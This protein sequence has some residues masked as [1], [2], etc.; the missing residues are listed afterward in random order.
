MH[1]LSRYHCTNN[2]EKDR[3]TSET[4]RQRT[5]GR[6]AGNLRRGA[7]GKLI[8]VEETTMLGYHYTDDSSQIPVSLRHDTNHRSECKESS[9]ES[10]G[11]V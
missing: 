5:T 9:E 10:S 6:S 8:L 11:V 2:K 7:M 4:L 1:G 3:S